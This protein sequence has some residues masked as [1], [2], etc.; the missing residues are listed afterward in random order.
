MSKHIRFSPKPFKKQKGLWGKSKDFWG[1]SGTFGDFQGLSG[2]FGEFSLGNHSMDPRRGKCGHFCLNYYKDKY[3]IIS[4]D[5]ETLLR[6]SR[7]YDMYVSRNSLKGHLKCFPDGVIKNIVSYLESDM[8]KVCDLMSMKRICNYRWCKLKMCKF[9]VSSH[10]KCKYCN[11]SY[12]GMYCFQEHDC[13]K[14]YNMY[15]MDVLDTDSSDDDT[16][17]TVS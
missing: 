11:E 8:C 4:S 15:N 13:V 17:C 6:R 1:F 3:Y 9:C 2:D 7:M 10:I 14:H 16:D 12:C 5:A